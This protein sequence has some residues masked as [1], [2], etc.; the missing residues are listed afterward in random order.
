M[1]RDLSRFNLT[2]A[3]TYFEFSSGGLTPIWLVA[4]LEE[5]LRSYNELRL[6]VRDYPIPPI[7]DGIG[8]SRVLTLTI[9]NGVKLKIY[10]K[11]DRRVRVEV[12]HDLTSALIP[13]EIG[14]LGSSRKKHTFATIEGVARLLDALRNDAAKV[15]NDVFRH[16]RNSA[17]L[18]ATDKTG[19]DL[20]RDF[21]T[22]VKLRDTARILFDAL[23]DKG[24]ITSLTQ[25]RVA[26][27]RLRK[28]GILQTQDTNHRKEHV[29][30]AQY[31]HA[32]KMLREHSAF[33]HLTIRH[34]TR[35][36]RAPRGG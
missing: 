36:D 14:D 2:C 8:M 15:V 17:A 9:R 13:A 4:S 11:T 25:Y 16:L 19:I 18:P 24:S 5:P 10:A 26:L 1:Q 3:E 20:V 32:L 29:V 33:P 21:T 12:V 35:M 34:R 27:A 28:A 30:T 6:R 23:I 31:R 7:W 22:T